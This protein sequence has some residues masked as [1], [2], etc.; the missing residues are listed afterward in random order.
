MDMIAN[1]ER[2]HCDTQHSGR[3]IIVEFFI[4][5]GNWQGF[6]PRT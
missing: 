4:Q 3:D 2:N 6:I 5:P 1:T